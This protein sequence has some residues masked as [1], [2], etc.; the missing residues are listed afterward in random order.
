MTIETTAIKAVALGNGASTVWP[1]TFLI[2]EASDL[3]LKL[4]TVASGDETT[5]APANYTVTGIGNEAG[6]S[7]TY[8]LSG[9]PVSSAYYVVI[10]RV[11]PLTQET[12]LLNQGA[13]YPQSIE[14]ALDYLT[15]LTQQL[16]DQID[17]AIV[18]SV[19]DTVE[20]TLPTAAARANLF[21]GFNSDGDPVAVDGLTAGTTVSA[22]MIPVVT[23][24]TTAAALA[25]LGI[26]GSLLDALIPAGTIWDYAGTTAPSGFALAYGQACTSTYP[27]LRTLLVA[28]GSPFGTNGVD[29]LMPDCRSRSIVGKSNMGGMDN[30]LWT[31]GTVLGAVAGAQSVTLNT[32]QIP[33]HLHA[34]FLDDPGHFHQVKVNT[35]GGGSDSV[36][37]GAAGGS[38]VGTGSGP[39]ITNT[40]G[41]TVR[42]TSGGGG[43]ANQTATAGG[44]GSHENRHPGLILNKIIKAH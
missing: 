36:T 6:G 44:G 26:P 8:P 28:A 23:A 1:Y 17:R 40:T 4:V 20:T 30:G 9:S 3:Q 25:A 24:P 43:T 16:Q 39:I 37:Q 13:A 32:A 19:A 18:F 38:N 41:I 31:G 7:V 14:D 34:V 35:S 21:L 33:S 27:T 22:A 11:L 42:D 15:M 29:P 12:D 2:P 5:I 10:E